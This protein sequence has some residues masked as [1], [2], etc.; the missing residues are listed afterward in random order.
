M[1]STKTM[2]LGGIIALLGIGLIQQG[3]DLYLATTFP[4][5]SGNMLSTVFPLSSL[6]LILL[7][8]I[9]GIIGV[10]VRK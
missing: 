8:A 7:G 9:L 10:F 6:A 3:N 5:L 4:F 1:K 2:L